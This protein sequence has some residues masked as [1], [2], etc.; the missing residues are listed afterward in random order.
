MMIADKFTDAEVIDRIKNGD[1]ALY[2]IMVRRYN[3]YLYKVGRSYHFNHQDT[4]DLMQE[5]FIDA[6]KSLTKFEGRANFKTWIIRIML[7]NCYRKNSKFSFKY[8][9]TQPLNEAS[10]PMFTNLK[11]DTAALVQNEELGHVIEQ[12]LIKIPHH[13]RMAFSLREINGL[14]ISETASLLC[15]TEANV[16]VRVNRAKAMLRNEIEKTYAA[17]ELFEFNFIY[18]DAMLEAVMKKVMEL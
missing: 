8:E 9:I 2:E 18:C 1:K 14:N 11:N 5:T 3:P 16:K 17:S 13:Y 7:N 12:A 6:Y 10:T 4:Q 15:I